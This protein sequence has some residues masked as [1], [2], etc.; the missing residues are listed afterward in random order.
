MSMKCEITGKKSMVGHNVSHA[1]NKTK[2][3]FN[4]NLKVKRFYVAEEN[5]W[6]TLKVSASAIRT[7]NKKGI[8]ACLKEA[9]AKGY[10]NK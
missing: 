8:F 7:I 3:L 6:V 5:R 9:R 1:N 10:T 2:R 4:P